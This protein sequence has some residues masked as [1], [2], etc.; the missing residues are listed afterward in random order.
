MD[1]DAVQSKAW[2]YY[3]ENIASENGLCDPQE[4][5]YQVTRLPS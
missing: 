5:G 2:I 3:T 1:I 4:T